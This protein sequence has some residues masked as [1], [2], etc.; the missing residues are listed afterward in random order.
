MHDLR[1]K[2]SGSSIAY[3]VGIWLQL[4]ISCVRDE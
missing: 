1:L 2:P 3:G 4:A